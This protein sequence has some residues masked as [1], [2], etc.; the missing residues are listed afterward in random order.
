MLQSSYVI[1]I[2][3]IVFFIFSTNVPLVSF[4]SFQS[5]AGL[6]LGEHMPNQIALQENDYKISV[7]GVVV[8]GIIAA[9]IAGGIMFEFFQRKKKTKK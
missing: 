1:L 9:L 4:E 8:I 6:A 3:A 2:T 5:S 7:F